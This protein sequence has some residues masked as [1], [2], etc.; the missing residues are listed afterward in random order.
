MKRNGTEI[1]IDW[2]IQNDVVKKSLQGEVAWGDGIC[3][4]PHDK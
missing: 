4:S 2:V 3:P 1:Q